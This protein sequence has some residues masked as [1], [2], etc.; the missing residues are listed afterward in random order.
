MNRGELGK[1]IDRSSC[2]VF[3]WQDATSDGH[4]ATLAAFIEAFDNSESALLVEPSLS[5][6]ST[7]PP[8]IVLIDPEVGVHV[9][10]VKALSLAQI[11]AIEPGGVLVIRYA[12][13]TRRRN[14]IAQVRSAMFDIKDA[15]A[16]AFE[17]DL[18]IPFRYWVVFPRIHRVEWE[19]RFG[20]EGFCPPELL[21]AD[22]LE[23]TSLLRRLHATDRRRDRSTPIRTCRLEELQNVWTAFGDNS[24]LYVRPEHRPERKVDEGTLGELFDQRAQALK[25]LSAEQQRLSEMFW[26]SGPRL[27]RG[28]AGSGKT[29]VLANNLARRIKRLLGEQD[30]SLFGRPARRPR[31]AAV[32]F[33]RTLAPFIAG[34]IAAAFE[35]RTGR[36]LPEGVVQVFPLNKLVYE[37][38]RAGLWA[39]QPPKSVDETTRARRYHEQLL[40]FRES[41]PTAFERIAFDAIYVDEGQ[42]FVEAEFELLRDLCLAPPGGEPNL[43]VFYD[44]AQNLYGRG[45]PNWASL[46]LNIRGRAF[47]MTEC[48]RNPRPIVETSFNVLYGTALEGKRETPTR[49]FGD[50]ATLQDKK[51]IAMEGGRWRVLFARRGGHPPMLT[52]AN[53]REGETRLL[54]ARLTL[55]VREERVRPQDILVLTLSRDR[56]QEIADAIRRERIAGVSGVHL[57]FKEKDAPLCP[58]GKVTVSTVHSAKGYDAFIVLL[59]GANDFRTD[60]TGR[61]CFYV[62]CTRAVERL[63]VFASERGGLVPELMRLLDVR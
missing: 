28:V 16:R 39:Y 62:A 58:A 37:L 41:D 29:V 33:N 9:I 20:R 40:R 27:I 13:G 25:Q 55:L 34:K 36:A 12:Q 63:E 22:D 18:T 45:R 54:L 26:E 35:Q 30:A 57:A 60:V 4:R 44:D 15:T 56:A 32:C 50:I 8:D 46:G 49:D 11:E 38:S 21:F 52:L 42:D 31:I 6:K 23:R 47:V 51:L 7:R 43:Y 3:G 17:Q 53:D 5:R 59:A 61:A 48:F 10:E 14:A 24:V 19:A 2:R 1:L